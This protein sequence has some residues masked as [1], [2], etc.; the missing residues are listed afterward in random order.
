MIIS[1]ENTSLIFMAQNDEYQG[2]FKINLIKLS[3]TALFLQMTR[4]FSGWFYSRYYCKTDSGPG[5]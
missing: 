5:H 1:S 4:S 2:L 3:G